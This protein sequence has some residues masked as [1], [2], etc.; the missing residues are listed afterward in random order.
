M[1]IREDITKIVK[2]SQPSCGLPIACNTKCG[3]CGAG[4][5][6]DLLKAEVEKMEK[7]FAHQDR[8]ASHGY[9]LAIQDILK[10]LEE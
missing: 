5:I 8:M 9:G 1:S 2:Q 4:R 7:Q 6:I 3:E 10:L